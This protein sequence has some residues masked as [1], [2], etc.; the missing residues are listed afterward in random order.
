[1]RRR[2]NREG[3]V[4]PDR[5]SGKA[6]LDV[7][8]ILQTFNGPSPGGGLFPVSPPTPESEMPRPY[9]VFKMQSNLILPGS[10]PGDATR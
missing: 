2:K 8:V 7:A 1:M 6:A 4:A 9:M 10:R 3:N 5:R